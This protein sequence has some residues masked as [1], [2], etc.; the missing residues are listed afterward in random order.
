MQASNINLMAPNEYSVEAQALERRRKLAELMQ[1]Q[2]LEPLQAP[3]S[4]GGW[5][6]PMSPLAP[7]AKML[8]GYAGGRGMQQADERSKALAARIRGDREADYGM[9]M[10]GMQG[11]PEQTIQP[12]PQEVSQAADYGTPAVAPSTAPAIAPG[13]FNPAMIAQLRTPET[14]QAAMNMW[15]QQQKPTALGRSLVRPGTGEVIATDSTWKLE[16]DAARAS[17]ESEATLRREEAR[18]A[19][20]REQSW[21]DQQARQAA[22]E[23]VD[24]A[25]QTSADRAAMR[26]PPQPQ[27]LVQIMGP[28]GPIWATREQATGQVP[29]G[30]GS[31]AEK[32]AEGKQ[33]LSTELD[34]LREDYKTLNES[35]AIPSS[36]RGTAS[37]VA[38]WMQSSGAGQLL[39][40]MGGTKEQDARNRIQSAR[41][42]VMN[43]IK[44]ATGMSA[45]QLNSNVELQTW[46]SALTDP[47]KSYES[48]IG[49]IDAIDTVFVRGGQAPKGQRAGG[50]ITP[51]RRSTDRSIRDQADAILKGTP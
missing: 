22:A 43:A 15:M 14:Q 36:E 27:P 28:N 30:P 2:S 31:K 51:Q 3:P 39:G 13:Q 6:V 7:L 38:S 1:Q 21:R 10:Q 17:R 19:Q 23:R 50:Q 32:V 35:R 40:R 24:L 18:A 16:Q 20:A 26:Q 8:Q 33:L 41:L 46:L 48:N 29:A 42:R 44:N 9:L 49:I 4:S 37:N 47:S 12:D 34:N 5:A 11:R 45:Q 25:R